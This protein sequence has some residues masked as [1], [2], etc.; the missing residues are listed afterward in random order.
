MD[1]KK[2]EAARKREEAEFDQMVQRYRQAAASGDKN[3][4]AAARDYFQSIVQGNRP[5]ADSAQQYLADIEKK[6]EVLNQPPP[7]PP[8]PAKTVLNPA[9][10]D[11]AAIRAVVD[12]FFQ[13]FQQRNLDGLKEV[14]PGMPREKSGKY[15]DSFRHVSAIGIQIVSESV[16]ISPDGATA[17][18]SVQSEEQ[19]TPTGGKTQKFTPAWTFQLAKTNG[20]WVIS[21][22][23]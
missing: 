17:T 6:L 1:K 19:E 3:G 11:E 18:V 4:L 8:P 15:K 23:L 12:R 5:S 22:V 20:A 2:E 16:K 9:A 7:P 13:S 14:W 21:D 10:A